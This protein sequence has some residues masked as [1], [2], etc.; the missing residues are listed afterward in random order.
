MRLV[1]TP[2][3]IEQSYELL[4][5]TPPFRGWGLPPG[6]DVGFH[7]IRKPSVRAEFNVVGGVPQIYVTQQSAVMLVSL[8]AHVAHEM[9]HLRQH[10]L[11]LPRTHGAMFIKLRDQVCRWHGFDPGMF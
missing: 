5:T 9:V 3:M 10:L 6:D 11:G 8:L 2:A 1:L 7:V 4:R